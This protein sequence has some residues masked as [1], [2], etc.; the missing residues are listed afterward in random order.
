MGQPGCLS[1]VFLP[2]YDNANLDDYAAWTFSHDAGKNY[3]LIE[4]KKII[5]GGNTF[6]RAKHLSQD[7]SNGSYRYLVE[8][9]RA[10][11][12]YSSYPPFLNFSFA[13]KGTEQ[14]SKYIKDFE[15][16][17]ATLKF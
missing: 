2:N 1:F 16:I 17:L 8:M 3:S 12:E 14:E 7:G 9:S 10:V 5:L 11:P 4:N 13:F 15:A 6:R